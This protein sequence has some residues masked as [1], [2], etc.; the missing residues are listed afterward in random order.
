MSANSGTVTAIVSV[1]VVSGIIIS[2]L[3]FYCCSCGGRQPRG[4][5]A[6]RAEEWDRGRS[7]RMLLKYGTSRPRRQDIEMAW[8]PSYV[9]VGHQGHGRRWPT[10]E[11]L[12]ADGCD[13]SLG[14]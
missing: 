6:R 3:F 1:A 5:K 12:Y 7:E 10:V 4:D 13:I 2:I 11:T 9:V 8:R 14:S